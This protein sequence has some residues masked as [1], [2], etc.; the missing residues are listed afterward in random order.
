MAPHTMC[1]EEESA[2]FACCVLCTAEL[3]LHILPL[4]IRN[5]GQ[6]HP[7]PLQ[8]PFFCTWFN[9]LRV[10]QMTQTPTRILPLFMLLLV[11]A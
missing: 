7:I 6:A 3:E 1:T 2:K 4:S 8:L 9:K 10:K 11:F 5:Q